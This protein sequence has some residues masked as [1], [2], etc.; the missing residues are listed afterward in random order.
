MTPTTTPPLW[1]RVLEALAWASLLLAFIIGQIAAQT[2]YESLLKQQMPDI[3]LTRSQANQDL[4]VVYLMESDGKLSP[5]VV[6]MS[7]GVDLCQAGSGPPIRRAS[8]PNGPS[9]MQ[10]GSDPGHQRSGH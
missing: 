3:K 10:S 5:D 2:D 1:T 7:E 9:S 6:I 4:P 8:D